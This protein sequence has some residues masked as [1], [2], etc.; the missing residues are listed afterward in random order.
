MEEIILKPILTII[1]KIFLI[2]QLIM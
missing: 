2:I 1:L